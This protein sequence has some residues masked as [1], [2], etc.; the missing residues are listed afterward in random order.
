MPHADITLPGEAGSVPLA[1]RFV[2]QTLQEWG[3]DVLSWPASVVV[4]ELAAN[5]AIHARTDFTLSM[6]AVGRD[7]VRVELADGSPQVPR[8]RAY[9][10][11][12]TTGRGL[13]LVAQLAADWGATSTATGKTVWVTLVHDADQGTGTAEGDV[14]SL[15]GA[16]FDAPDEEHPQ[17]GQPAGCRQAA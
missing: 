7:R 11:E 9:G 1:R 10:R 15:L 12:S 2:Q 5:A 13:R 3:L 17:A 6:T 4:T 8:P 16:F 14:E